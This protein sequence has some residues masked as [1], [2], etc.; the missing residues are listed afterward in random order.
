[1]STAPFAF[2]PA[3]GWQDTASI[4]TKP[5]TEARTRQLLQMFHSQTRDFINQVLAGGWIPLPSAVTLSYSAADPPSFTAGASANLT[6]CIGPGTRLK[7]TQNGSVKYF[8]VTAATAS[9]LTLYGGTD[10]TLT[11]SAISA[12]YWSAAKAPTG[13][14]LDPAK[15]T[16]T[17][18][19]T[20]QLYQQNPAAGTWYNP[21]GWNPNIPIGAWRVE[22]SVILQGAVASAGYTTAYCTFSSSASAETNPEFTAMI[23]VYGT[24]APYGQYVP[25]FRSAP[26]TVTSKTVFYMNIKTGDSNCNYVEIRGDSARSIIRAICAYL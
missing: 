21:A 15:W 17:W 1:M 11:S 14:P 16:V 18:V 12:V 23:Q 22:Y 13:F 10:Y 3:S 20:A 26:L 4:E 6:D 2:T 7:L 5:A 9:S 8:I 25:V 24:A 19:S